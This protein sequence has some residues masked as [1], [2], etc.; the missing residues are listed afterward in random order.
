MNY[1]EQ[2]RKRYVCYVFEIKHCTKRKETCLKQSE[3]DKNVMVNLFALF[4][5]VYS[6]LTK[7]KCC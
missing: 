4:H 2:Q 7:G 1:S 3:G 6:L 5:C